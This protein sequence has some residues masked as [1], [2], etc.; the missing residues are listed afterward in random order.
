M[1]HGFRRRREEM[2]APGKTAGF[3]TRQLDPR[4]MDEGGWLEGLAGLQG[5]HFAHRQP[6]Q[7]RVDKGEQLV[8]GLAV[9][10]SHG[11][12]NARERGH[13]RKPT[14]QSPSWQG[15]CVDR[16]VCRPTKYGRSVAALLSRLR[17]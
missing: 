6:A 13:C 11:T 10:G 4:L 14:G 16:I 7:F 12:K 2:R 17:F 9:T 1:A 5:G 15:L 3:V 8:V